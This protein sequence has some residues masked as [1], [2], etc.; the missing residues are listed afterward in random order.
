MKDI[1][2]SIM[3]V[4]LM[5]VPASSQDARRPVMRRQAETAVAGKDAQQ[6]GAV[7]RDT[8]C[9]EREKEVARFCSND[10]AIE[11]ESTPLIR[12]AACG[13]LDTVR[14]LLKRGVDVNEKD[15]PGFTALMFAA[16]GNLEIAKALLDAGAD[17]N[18]AW[19]IAHVGAW[20]VLMSAIN[21][22]NENRLA[23]L[24]LL[25]AGGAKIDPVN[26]SI[27]NPLEIAITND[28]V[29]LVK[30]LLK[31]GAD[32]NRKSLT[33]ETPVVDTP[34]ASAVRV[35][36]PDVEI[37]RALLEAGADPNLPMLS[38]GND[39]VSLLSYLDGWLK[40]PVG[41]KRVEDKAR[42]E[43]VR[44]LEQ[45]GGK[46]VRTPAQRDEDRTPTPNN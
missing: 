36:K 39:Y 13:D 35:A 25:I 32:A 33:P 46:R 6:G 27:L 16:A 24:D 41:V 7:T 4:A 34:L 11:L 37:V 5:A 8:K 1:V 21:R 18:A 40:G 31:R 38:V 2:T 14:A 30:A 29:P 23:M 22:C 42:E 3:C 10:G 12:A 45:A 28:D 20:S 44:L 19:G 43:I 9:R 17:P 26:G 15:G